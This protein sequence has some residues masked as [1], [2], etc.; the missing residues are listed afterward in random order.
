MAYPSRSSAQ[1]CVN[2][3]ISIVNA[4]YESASIN[5]NISTAFTA[6]ERTAIQAAFNAFSAANYNTGGNTGNCSNVTWNIHFQASPAGG[7]GTYQ[8]FKT[9]PTLPGAQAETGGG[10]DGQRRVSAFTRIHP[11]VTNSTAL[12]QAM[13]HE[14]GHTFALADCNLCTAGASVM[15]LYPGGNLNDTS[16]GRTSPAGCDNDTIKYRRYSCTGT[17]PLEICINVPGENPLKT[18]SIIRP[19]QC[20]SPILVDVANDGYSLT[21]YPN[22]VTF[23][24]NNRLFRI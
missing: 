15:T 17:N 10:T 13:A 5:V 6:S 18:R 21:D 8:V 4:W 20:S 2:G 14:I 7:P 12:T 9:I 11:G 22:G 16:W 19:N 23:D 3:Q 1:L 24:L